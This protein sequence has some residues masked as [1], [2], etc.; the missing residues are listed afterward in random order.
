MRNLHYIT[1]LILALGSCVSQ[2]DITA[3]QAPASMQFEVL[4][5][6]DPQTGELPSHLKFKYLDKQHLGAQTLNKTERYYPNSWGPV[7]DQFAT[8]SV[9]KI[10]FDPNNTSVFYFCTGEGWFNAD[11]ARGAGIWKTIDGGESWSRLASTDTSIF[12]YCQDIA[13]HPMTSDVY[14][15]TRSSGL[16]RSTDGG[17]SWEQVLG[18]NNGANVNTAS[19]IELA[20]NGGMFVSMG[21]SEYDGIY[22]SETG[23]SGEWERRMNGFASNVWRI[24]I[25][26]AQSDSNV[27]YAIAE[28]RPS[29]NTR[30]SI[31][32]IYKSL[33]QGLNWNAVS[34]PDGNRKMA[35]VQAWYDLIIQV[36]PNNPNVVVIGGLNL[37]RSRDGGQSWQQLTEGDRRKTNSTL[38]Y[39]H[40]DQH[41]IIFKN[42]D[43]VYFGNDG[44][45]YRCNNFRD[46]IPYFVNMNQNYNV[47][48]FYSCD[49]HPSVDDEMVLGGT[50]DNG[51]NKSIS[52]GVSEFENVSWAD[53]GFC[54]I[55]YEDGDYLYT[56]TQLR[57]MFRTY[58]GVRDTITNPYIQNDNTLFINPMIMDASNPQILYMASDRG[59]WRFSNA[60]T[61][62]DSAWQKCTRSFGVISAVASSK[63][64]PNNVY[65][66]RVVGGNTNSY[67]YRIEN[68]HITDD[69]YIPIPMDRNFELPQGGYINC[70]LVDPRDDNHVLVVYSNYNILSVFETYNANANDPD[71]VNLDTNL[72]NIP[73]RWASFHPE[74]PSVCYLA[75]E[76]G[77]YY[78]DSLNGASTVWKKGNN[79]LPNLRMDMIKYRES[80]GKFVIGSHGRGIY[81]GEVAEGSNDINWMERGPNNIGGRTRAILIDPNDPSGR[82]VWAGSVSGGLWLAN[83]IDSIAQYEEIY[84]SSAL[85]IHPNPASSYV[86][87][88]FNPESD[89]NALILIYN[90]IGQLISS[91]ELETNAESVRYDIDH[92]SEG[93]YFFHLKQ[94]DE[95]LSKKMIIHKL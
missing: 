46:E 70:I 85:N 26:T 47:T 76:L 4:R 43:T 8:L 57:R 28:R 73:I 23:N 22:Y 29:G 58:K 60:R 42:S 39:V 61:S 67:P 3:E 77:M 6:A 5:T 49:I 41:E 35:N 51:S 55:D 71:W 84:F 2:S 69:T 12:F 63:S 14:V 65:I 48:Q 72:P 31:E 13:V 95:E 7:D 66:A 93:L 10:A 81:V 21:M 74:N 45:I 68:A 27:I 18:Q 38:Q 94:G 24:E 90:E 78:T 53:G 92:L 88:Y 44:G 36:D 54:A 34:L 11:A 37:W 86:R 25:A 33:D 56:T 52:N 75:T 17:N 15:C 80:D 40:V 82:K 89:E 87:L 91:E 19:D 62:T 59:L 16:M 79:S 1:L 30:D 20:A 32:G 50:Q 83:N 9:T 64:T